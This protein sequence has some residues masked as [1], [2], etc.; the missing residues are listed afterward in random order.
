MA[1]ETALRVRLPN[2]PGELARV[3]R[4]LATS[5]VTIRSVAGLTAGGEGMVEFLVDNLPT[6]TEALTQAGIDYQEIRVVLAPI[7]GEVIDQPGA[8]ANLAETLARAGINIESIYA[9]ARSSGQ[10]DAVLGSSDP[11]RAESIL[12]SWGL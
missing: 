6:A 9:A 1:I 11:E 4:Q 10:A 2:R 5:G 12:T 3:A 7:P 8:L